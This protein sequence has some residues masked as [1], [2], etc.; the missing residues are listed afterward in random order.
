VV[1]DDLKVLAV[2]VLAHRLLLDE[3]SDDSAPTADDVIRKVLDT[4]PV[5]QDR[6]IDDADQWPPSGG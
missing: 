2:P 6:E 1:D 3:L 4:V 5:P